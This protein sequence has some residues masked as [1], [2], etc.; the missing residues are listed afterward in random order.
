MAREVRTC[1]LCGGIVEFTGIDGLVYRVGSHD[2]PGS[3][4]SCR[5]RTL[6]RIRNLN[7]IVMVLSRELAA[8]RG[9]TRGASERAVELIGM[10]RAG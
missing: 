1:E 7:A 8:A 10:A 2:S 9:D 5:E 4:A 6:E 3:P